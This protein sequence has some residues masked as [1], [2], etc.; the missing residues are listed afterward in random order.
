[1][2]T[3]YIYN[4]DTGAIVADTASVK[5]DIEAEWRAALGQNMNADA[6]TPQGTLITADTLARTGVMRN[7]AELANCM[8]PT[9]A[10]GSFLDANCALLGIERGEHAS[11]IGYQLRA[12][13]NAQ[14]SVAAG[15]PFQA[16]SGDIYTILTSFVIP[17]SGVIN[18]VTVQSAEYGDIPLPVGD[19]VIIDGTIGWG[20]I[21]VLATTTRA[22]G[23]TSLTDS[24]LK[25]RR[26]KQ[27][28]LQG[29]GSS[30]AVA[31][32]LLEV[33]DVS[34]AIVVENNTGAV[35]EVNGVTFTLPSALWVC[36]AGNANKQA[37]AEA[38]YDA[39]QSGCP[40]DFGTGAGVPVDYDD[41]GVTVNDP[42]T[43]MPYKV[44]WTTPEMFDAFVDIVVSQGTSASAPDPAIANA[45]VKYANG[46]YEEEEGL[47][48]GA[49]L[50]AFEISGAVARQFPGM[51]VKSC[52]VAAVAQGEEPPAPGD[53][54][55]EVVMNPFQQA[56][57]L[58]G[59]VKVTLV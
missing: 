40:W 57:L 29:V 5:S 18:T 8:N 14:T 7:N 53:Y 48:V 43:N 35:G 32:R 51:Y 9:L 23:R 1:M 55:Y 52:K 11:T 37:V 25:T 4:L 41:G 6:S 58:V 47:V 2:T 27:L 30:R 16:S 45:C 3:S 54:T 31:S 34:S 21:T 59:N 44:K 39:H 15:S 38:L 19:M 12:T 36:V 17:P 46:E 56:Q 20:S 13:G 49:S 10:F 22:A 33:P 24:R 26:N 50:S 28:A 42:I